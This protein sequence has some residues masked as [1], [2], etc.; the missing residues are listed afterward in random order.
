MRN[1]IGAALTAALFTSASAQTAPL[2]S[3]PVDCELGETC[4]ITALVDHDPG[5]YSTDHACGTLTRDGHIGTDVTLPDLA[6]MA[7]GVPVT[8]AAPG[9]VRATRDRYPD[10]GADYGEDACGNAVVISHGDGW[11]TQYCH[12]REGSVAVTQGQRVAK[13]TRIGDVGRSGAAT[14]PHLD[15]ILWKDGSPVDPFAPATQGC[16]NGEDALWE[17]PVAVPLAG[18]LKVGFATAPP[19]YASIREAQ[20]GTAE[21][22]ATAPIIAWVSGYGS[23]PGDVLTTTITHQAGIFTEQSTI[24]ERRQEVWFRFTGRRFTDTPW[25]D[26]EYTARVTLMRQGVLLTETT[27]SAR[28]N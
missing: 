12:L 25:P 11:S 14:L 2:L 6:A 3:F 27:F 8:A 10:T 17:D 19:D 4:F 23:R 24:F 9:T 7:K 21:L 28:I 13:D 18:F 1:L 15:M 20:D 22:S 5:L 26:G 16:G